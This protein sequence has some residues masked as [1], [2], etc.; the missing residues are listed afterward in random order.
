M[1]KLAGKFFLSD[2]TKY[3]LVLRHHKLGKSQVVVIVADA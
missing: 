1:Q 2:M 3:N